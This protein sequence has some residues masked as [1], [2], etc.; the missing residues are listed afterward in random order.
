MK[1]DKRKNYYVVLDTEGLGL[2]DS[3][4]KI[5]GRQRSYDIGYMKTTHVNLKYKI[6]YVVP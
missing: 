1:I 2:N 3:K 4:K 6:I 5:Y